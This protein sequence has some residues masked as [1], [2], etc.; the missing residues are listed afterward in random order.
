MDKEISK[1]SAEAFLKSRGFILS[2]TT[3]GYD[4]KSPAGRSN[5]IRIERD[6]IEAL[7]SLGYIN[8]IESLPE[9]IHIEIYNKS[10]W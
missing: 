10:E 1:E 2:N 4:I 9:E 5:N 8:L 6:E 3:F 7:T